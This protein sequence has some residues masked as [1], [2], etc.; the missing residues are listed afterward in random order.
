MSSGRETLVPSEYSQSSSSAG[1]HG[2]VSSFDPE[3]EV[4]V[5]DL[6]YD[7]TSH[8]CHPRCCFLAG[9]DGRDKRLRATRVIENAKMRM[10]GR[11]AER[12]R[13]E[14]RNIVDALEALRVE[15]LWNFE[16][17]EYQ[18]QVRLLSAVAL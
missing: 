14:G 1:D 8:D 6:G 15:V 18:Q 2:S 3:L 11:I 7:I 5:C 4:V 16:P 9:V 12:E 13:D 17:K 10:R